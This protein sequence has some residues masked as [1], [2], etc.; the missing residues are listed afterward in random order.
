MM[1][2]CGRCKN[3]KTP[4]FKMSRLN[5]LLCSSCFEDYYER[6]VKNTVLKYGMLNGVNKLAIAASGGKDSMAL[7]KVF[8]ELFPHIKFAV[9]HLNLGIPG[10]SDE[11]IKV[12]E[13]FCIENSIELLVYDLKKY[14]GYTIGDLSN[15][16]NNK[17][18]CGV[19]GIV[20]RH[21]MNKVAYEN[22]FDTLATGH[23]LDD[24][25]EVLFNLYLNGNVE[26]MSRI[27]PVAPSMNPKLIRKIKP[28]IE[29]TDQEDLY[30][31]I[32][33]NLD[34]ASSECPLIKGSRMV[35]RKNLILRIEEEIPNF[36]YRFL[37]THLK[38]FLPI[39]KEH[40]QPITLRECDVCSMPSVGSIC[41]FCKLS[42][43][44]LNWVE[45]A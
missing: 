35:E 15:L 1:D 4:L 14:H 24:V 16:K 30:Y 37:K 17:R 33:K 40:S 10:H 39:L 22:G 38:R 34:Y 45:N 11:C 13:K 18:I 2:R 29:V 19:C 36:R 27:K 5:S 44:I 23:N 42:S 20:K 12:V 43:R 28:L 6:K 9:I 3:E 25:V 8:S 31:V 7:L 41:S 26:E 21:L 32:S